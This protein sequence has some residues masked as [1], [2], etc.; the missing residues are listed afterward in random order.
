MRARQE[1]RGFPEVSLLIRKRTRETVSSTKYCE[2]YMLL[3][4]AVGNVTSYIQ[5]NARAF[6]KPFTRFHFVRANAVHDRETAVYP[7]L[8]AKLCKLYHCV[9]SA[10]TKLRTA[11]FL[12]FFRAGRVKRYVD[13]VDF[14]FQLGHDI[15]FIDKIALTVGI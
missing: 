11:N 15:P 5:R 7:V 12:I 9:K 1:E 3:F 4:P 8:F 10:F 13:K 6:G 2:V 14:I